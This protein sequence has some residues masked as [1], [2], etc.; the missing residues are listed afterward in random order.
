MILIDA[1]DDAD[2]DD[3]DALMLMMLLQMLLMMLMQLMM[4]MMMLTMGGYIHEQVGNATSRARARVRG[5]S[6]CRARPLTN[7]ERDA[8]V[9]HGRPSMLAS[10]ARHMVD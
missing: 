2:D 6:P 9:T 10:S 5:I 1:D 8:C 3:A 4:M 7:H